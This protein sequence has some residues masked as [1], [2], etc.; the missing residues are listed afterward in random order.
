MEYET[1]TNWVCRLKTENVSNLPDL[2]FDELEDDLILLV[3][4]HQGEEDS[5]S[6]L[7]ELK[8]F[9][10]VSYLNVS[11]AVTDKSVVI[12]NKA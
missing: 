5:F 9:I 3:S 8:D 7:G 4:F 1:R 2:L 11:L 10:F 12:A 6:F